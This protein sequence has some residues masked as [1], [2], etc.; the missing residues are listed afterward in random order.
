MIADQSVK[1]ELSRYRGVVQKR[2]VLCV[3]VGLRRRLPHEEKPSDHLRAAG[4]GPKQP[5]TFLAKALA[6]QVNIFYIG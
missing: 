5:L 3:A 2:Y 1:S 4:V 6:L